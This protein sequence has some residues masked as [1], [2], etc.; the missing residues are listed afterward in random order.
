MKP[1]I[2]IS[3][4]GGNAANYTA[5]IEAAGGRAD[6]RYLPAPG[7]EYDGLVLT[8]GLSLGELEGLLAG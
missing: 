1:N 7:L 5:A 3:T 6:A 8:G 2:L 4:G